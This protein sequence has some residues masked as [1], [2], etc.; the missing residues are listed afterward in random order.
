MVQPPVIR[1]LVQLPL[2]Q[3]LQVPCLPL[4]CLG[5]P[6]FPS[7][8]ADWLNIDRVV[9]ARVSREQA[10]IP[11]WGVNRQSAPRHHQEGEAVE[12]LANCFTLERKFRSMATGKR[13]NVCT[14]RQWATAMHIGNPKTLL[15]RYIS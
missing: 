1:P 15:E 12:F 7:F 10:V 11:A 4:L 2:L 9:V 5:H 14:N 13:K 3:L 6:F 8:V